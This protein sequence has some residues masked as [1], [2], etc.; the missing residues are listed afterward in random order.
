MSDHRTNIFEALSSRTDELRAELADDWPDFLDVTVW[1]ARDHE[2]RVEFL[3]SC[4]GPTETV[5][6]DCGYET[7][8]YS[9]SW[10]MDAAGG[11]RTETGVWGDADKE[12]WLEAARM[13]AEMDDPR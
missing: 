4:G 9:H 7:V 1:A 11:D 3:L 6:V 13:F 5:T 8:T 10:G 2:P 12:P